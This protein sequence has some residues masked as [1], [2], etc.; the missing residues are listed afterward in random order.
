MKTANAVKKLEKA[1]FERLSGYR[2]ISYAKPNMNRVV[3]FLDQ[4]G[5]VICLGFRHKDD[6][7]DSMTDYCATIW[8]DSLAQAM[9]LAVL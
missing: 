6:H 9:R 8:C 5:S 3:E 1:G 2:N 7:S 4:E